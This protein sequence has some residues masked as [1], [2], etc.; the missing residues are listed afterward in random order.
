MGGGYPTGRSWNFWGS[1]PAFAAHVV[2]SWEGRIVFS[3]DDVGLHVLTGNLLM[4]Y[5]P[6]DDPVRQAYIYYNFWEPTSS[7][8]P[9][10]AVYTIEGL[11]DLL[12][13]I[14]QR[15]RVEPDRG[16]RHESVD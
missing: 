12:F 5:G 6:R 10:A 14:W 16:G 13:R 7:W 9:L 2:H 1:D 15:A 8:D 3:W 4:K 11:G